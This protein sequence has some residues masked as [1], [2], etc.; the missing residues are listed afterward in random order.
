[1]R[2]I[3]WDMDGVLFPFELS[4]TDE[5]LQSRKYYAEM[6]PVREMWIQLYEL[7]AEKGQAHHILSK[8]LCEEALAGK[9]DALDKMFF[10]K[11][12]RIFVPYGIA[13]SEYA[14]RFLMRNL[15]REDVLLDD[16]TANCIEWQKAGGTAIKVLNA[17]ND[18]SK[19][20]KGLKLT[21]SG[22]L[23]APKTMVDD[24]STLD[25][26]VVAIYNRAILDLDILRGKG[27]NKAER[28]EVHESEESIRRFIL[29]GQYGIDGEL[30]MNAYD[31]S[32]AL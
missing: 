2:H 22:E 26:L 4:A 21:R 28:E 25:D 9:H 5:Q 29:S 3:F 12:D 32:R 1:M 20:W 18:R 16:H 31:K 30:I 8:Y 17:I 27:R 13:K 15:R 24:K 19:R 6:L 11:E 14:R 23:I 7:A 10:P